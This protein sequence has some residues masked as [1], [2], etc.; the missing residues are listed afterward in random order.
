MKRFKLL[1]LALIAAVFMFAVPVQASLQDMQAS[2]YKWDGGMGTDGK[3]I[4]TQITSGITF[5]VLATGA[6]TAETLY[7]PNKTTSLTNPVTAANF[8]ST[9]VCNKRV[10]FRVDPTDA[11]NDRYVDL[12]VVDTA[13]GYTA[14]VKNFDKYTHTIV[15]DERPG[16]V[17]HGVIW[18]TGDT[19]NA[20]ST[21]INFGKKTTITNV[22]LEVVTTGNST[23]SIGTETTAN[24]FINAEIL[25]TAGFLTTSGASTGALLG[26]G[27]AYQW[28]HQGTTI[29]AA[30]SY[31]YYT[32]ATTS[33]PGSAPAGY[34]HYYFV[35]AR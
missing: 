11:T 24:A 16:V 23:I 26:T 22:G 19:T 1:T 32:A 18:F 14:I 15:I 10:A 33:T 9:S 34:I 17:Q 5:K 35:K 29:T 2:V 31:L 8:A 27:T 12:I 7:Y 3:A 30:A 25:T 21:G 20:K 28:Y 4:V 13:G 6:D